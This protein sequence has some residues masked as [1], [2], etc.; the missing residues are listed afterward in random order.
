M[1]EQ[2]QLL[3]TTAE[4]LCLSKNVA[5]VASLTG[6]Q[7][8]LE[9]PSSPGPAEDTAGVPTAGREKKVTNVMPPWDMEL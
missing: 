2:A 6:V 4:F 3:A 5:W 9:V 8:I 7:Y 1:P